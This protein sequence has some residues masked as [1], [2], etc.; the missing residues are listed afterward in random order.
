MP[1]SY[2]S[3]V[4]RQVSARLRSGEPVADIA[5]E[6]GISPATLFRWKAQ[7]LIDAGVREGVPSTAADELA[8]A[9]KR[10]AQLESELA[11]TRD[12]CALFDE[13]VVIAPEG[14]LRSS[15]D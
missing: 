8:S 12:A 2:S 7:A 11:L 1:K 10:I 14:R 6:T 5:S 13:G 9:H 3:S 4:R 15:K